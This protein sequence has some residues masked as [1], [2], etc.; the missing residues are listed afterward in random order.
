MPEVKSGAREKYK[1]YLENELIDVPYIM[2]IYNYNKK[3]DKCITIMKFL[4]RIRIF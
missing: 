3:I 4:N 2:P 1:S